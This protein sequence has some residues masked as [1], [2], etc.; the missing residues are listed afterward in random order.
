[1]EMERPTTVMIDGR[2]YPITFC[3]P[4]QAEGS[5]PEVELTARVSPRRHF[6]GPLTTGDNDGQ[7]RPVI[8]A[9]GV[10]LWPQEMYVFLLEMTTC[11]SAMIAE[12]C[13]PEEIKMLWPKQPGHTW[14]D[15]FGPDKELY[16]DRVEWK[17]RKLS[18]Y[19]LDRSTRRKRDSVETLGEGQ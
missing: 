10:R 11:L 4:A 13:S 6:V 17:N 19:E 3:P 5:T 8:R 2:E 1:M 16:K 18:N 12:V 15:D 9:C 7:Y 14:L